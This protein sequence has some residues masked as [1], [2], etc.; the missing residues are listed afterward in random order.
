M[1]TTLH[2]KQLNTQ[3]QKYALFCG[4]KI[5]KKVQKSGESAH[6]TTA[7]Q[8]GENRLKNKLIV[9][10]RW[11]RHAARRPIAKIRTPVMLK[12]TKIHKPT[13]YLSNL[14]V[15]RLGVIMAVTDT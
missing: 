2:Q 15:R 7:T 14:I 9:K 12:S 1:S 13:D 8:P 6:P 3:I 10:N 4:V 5:T 11:F